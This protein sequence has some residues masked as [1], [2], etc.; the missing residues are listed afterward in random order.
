[1]TALRRQRAGAI[2]CPSCGRLVGVQ[3][4]RCPHCGR[5][6][7][8]LWGFAPALR[9][10]FGDVGFEAL[11]IGVCAA[12]YLAT[13]AV[14]PAGVGG[15]GLGLL[16]PSPGSLLLFGA[17]GP[18]PVFELGRWWTPL[19]AG[20]L[21]GGLLHILFNLLWVRQLAPAAAAIYGTPRTAV[22]YTLS[23]VV[24]FVASSLGG[25]YL[26]VLQVILGGGPHAYTVGASAAIFGLLGAIV[27]A[28][29]RGIA[30]DL[31]RQAWIYA[32]ALFAFGLLLGGIDNWAHLGGFAGGYALGAW[33]DPQRPERLDDVIGAVTCLAAS[34]AAVV[35]SAVVR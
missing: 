17:S 21:H 18:G 20:W 35:A 15:R 11:V 7:P 27:Y 34:A 16:G 25:R 31:G 26:G 24:G 13:L 30:M 28:G 29:R 3:E 23:S 4:P 14:D 6:N 12:L 19:S 1:M 33:L 22:L 10:L 9:R 5:V 8:G 2:V 32:I